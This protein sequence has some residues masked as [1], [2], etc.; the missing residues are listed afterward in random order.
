[1]KSSTPAPK[2]DDAAT[3]LDPTSCPTRPLPHRDRRY[4]R[5]S[6]IAAFTGGDH[7]VTYNLI[8]IVASRHHASDRVARFLSTCIGSKRHEAAASGTSYGNQKCCPARP[9]SNGLQKKR[10]VTKLH[11]IGIS[12]PHRHAVVASSGGAT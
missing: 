10:I 5:L 7:A 11:V 12:A 8:V 6:G 9:S 2:N 3:T 1:M 4:F